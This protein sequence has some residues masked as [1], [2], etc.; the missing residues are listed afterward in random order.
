MARYVVY[1]TQKLGSKGKQVEA[2]QA[3]L[4]NWTLSKHMVIDGIFGELTESAVKTFQEE[5]GLNADGV[6]GR[7]TGRAL[8]IWCTVEQGFDASHWNSILWDSIPA[9]IKFCILKATQGSSLTDDK[10]VE[11]VKYASYIGLSVGAYHYT[12]FANSPYIEAAN[13]LNTIDSVK[14]S[15]PFDRL[16]L[17]LECRTSGL[18]A[19][20]IYIWTT[21]FLNTVAGAY[22]RAKVGIY[23]SQ[24]YLSEIG[25]QPYTDLARYELWAANWS[26]QPYVYPWELWKTWQYTS[27]GSVSWAEGDLDLN[28]RICD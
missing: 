6:V 20:A 21:N 1:S 4:P 11:S 25:L 28:Y 13:F 7:I 23:T 12:T 8:E 16:Y 27:R 14:A 17:D 24:S 19:E 18:N 26:N 3:A 15:S 9:E 22:P 2:I 10:F 5:N